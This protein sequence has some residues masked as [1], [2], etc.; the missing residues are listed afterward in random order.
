MKYLVGPV[1]S[2]RLGRSL[3]VD[4]L[5]GECTFLCPYCE[6]RVRHVE[7]LRLF[8]FKETDALYAEYAEFCRTRGPKDVDSVTFSGTGEPTLIS[9]LGE[10]LRQFRKI[11]PY[12]LTVI[13]NGSLLYNRQ[14]RR[15]LREADL[16]V[17]SLDAVTES[18]WRRVNRPHPDL[19]L[20]KYLEGTRRFC[21]EHQGRIWLEV[22]L[23]RGMNDRPEDMEALGRF[24]K[25][26]RVERVQIGSVDRP[27]ARTRAAPVPPEEL[28]R[29][30]RIV[31]R[32][33]GRRVE[34]LD[35]HPTSDVRRPPFKSRE[36]GHP[37]DL[38][39]KILQ[40]VRLR[41]QTVD[42]L[43]RLLALPRVDVDRA[44]KSLQASGL[45]LSRKHGRRIFLQAAA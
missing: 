13:T 34:V 12:P 25:K 41:P 3:G 36:P 32:L 21:S 30:A 7:N 9:N 35:R 38:T 18:A 15:N 27:P 39:Q 24:L 16:V 10:I 11:G 42:E 20:K 28:S 43:S 45:I 6:V 31:R 4:L 14:V 1:F 40:S 29:L 19:T 37:A 8:E 26:L 5:R 2:R 22:L 44:R 17:P 33:S 23:V